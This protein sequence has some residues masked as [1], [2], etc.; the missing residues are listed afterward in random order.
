LALVLVLG[1]LAG[2]TAKTPEAST[3]P[4]QASQKPEGE[5]KKDVVIGVTM[6]DTTSPSIVLMVNAM[7]EKA[8]EYGNVTLKVVDYESD[9]LKLTESVENFVSAGVDCI[10]AQTMD[11]GSGTDALK[12][13]KDAGITVIAFDTALEDGVMDY[14]FGASNYDLGFTI[15]S[16]AGKWASANIE[17]KV[18]AGICNAPDIAFAVERSNGIIDGI[19]AECPEV[20]IAMTAECYMTTVGV[21]TGENFLN[22]NPNMNLVAGINDGGVLGV[23]EAFK[24]AGKAENKQIG[25][26]GG[27]GTPDGFNAV[28]AKDIFRGTVS[29][30][31]DEIG[32]QM[33]KCAYDTAN[34]NPPKETNVYFPMI[35]VSTD[36]VAD[37]IK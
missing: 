14:F 5:A 36:N 26:F 1:C 8:K 3:P 29:L 35:P 19:K 24:A 25:I 16:A 15:G 6:A 18:I 11:S 33:V 23:Y 10:I 22:A 12:V 37:F 17:G 27:D 28:N 2:C 20:E 13:A 9:I 4:Q 30:K 7:Q 21:E 32:V 34:G 31:L